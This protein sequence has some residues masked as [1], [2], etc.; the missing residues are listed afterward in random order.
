M[1]AVMKI[2]KKPEGVG[3]EIKNAADSSSNIMIQ[4]EINKGK[5]VMQTKKWQAEFDAGT[6]T[7]LRLLEPWFGS[8]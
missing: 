1:P 6:A 7:A 8:N 2:R 5:D 3:Y 4:I